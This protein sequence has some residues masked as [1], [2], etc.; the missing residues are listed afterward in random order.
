MPNSQCTDLVLTPICE[1][2][3]TY[4][5]PNHRHLSPNVVSADGST[6][7]A[8]REWSLQRTTC[9]YFRFESLQS[10]VFILV[11]WF[12]AIWRTLENVALSMRGNHLVLRV[13]L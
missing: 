11:E 13:Q 4:L 3:R 8:M 9:R 7:E 5:R 6:A 2:Q 12:L 10:A 1:W